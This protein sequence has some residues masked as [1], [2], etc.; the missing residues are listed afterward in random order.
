MAL[1][2]CAECG[3]EISS[4]C[5]ACLRCGS[6]TPFA[7][8]LC[9]KR[10]SGAPVPAS[11]PVVPMSHELRTAMYYGPRGWLAPR[12]VSGAVVCQ[13]HLLVRCARCG[14]EVPWCQGR[15]H[16]FG[17]EE[18]WC[19]TCDQAEDERWRLLTEDSR[20]SSRR[21]RLGCGTILYALAAAA[22][23]V[24]PWDRAG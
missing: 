20:A 7:C 24:V 23:L 9:G 15:K 8:S 22:A 14:Q 2:T 19:P 1:L 18:V 11:R 10:V 17:E 4:D 12:L 13:D 3:A 21:N 6:R 16:G 5:E